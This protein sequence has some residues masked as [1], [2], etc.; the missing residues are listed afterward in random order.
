MPGS[1]RAQ[2]RWGSGS[3]IRS[4]YADRCLRIGKMRSL[5]ETRKRRMGC[6]SCKA[7]KPLKLVIFSV[8]C[9]ILMQIW[10]KN[11][12]I[13]SKFIEILVKK[14]EKSTLRKLQGQNPQNANFARF[15]GPRCT[16]KFTYWS[17]EKIRG[18]PPFPGVLPPPIYGGGG[19]SERGAGKNMCPEEIQAAKWSFLDP[20]FFKIGKKSEKIVKKWQKSA[21][22]SQKKW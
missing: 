14:V 5:S 17:V 19:G 6:M 8:F 4:A 7:L 16:L 22:N 2:I 18:S 10:W 3:S 11:D 20:S 9:S 1:R 15:G 13:S 21:K 12:Q